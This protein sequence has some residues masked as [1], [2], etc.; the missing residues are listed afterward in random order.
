MNHKRR[1][2][3]FLMALMLALSGCSG[4]KPPQMADA[5]ATPSPTAEVTA[6]PEVTDTPKPT[7][8]P[9]PIPQ[10]ML[11]DIT[12]FPPTCQANGYSV[13]VSR[14]TGGINVRDEVPRLQHDYGE[15]D[16]DMATG[17]MSRACSMCGGEDKRRAD[18]LPRLLLFG[19]TEALASLGE[20]DMEVRFIHPGASDGF[21]GWAR[22]NW[23]GYSDTARMK[24]DVRVRFFDDE[25]LEQ[26]HALTLLNGMALSEYPLSANVI[27]STQQRHMICARVWRQISEKSAVG[28]SL[29]VTIYVNGDFRGLYALTLPPGALL[30]GMEPGQRQAAVTPAFDG[31]RTPMLDPNANWRVL[32]NGEGDEAWILDELHDLADFLRDS[33]DADLHEQL[34]AYLDTDSAIDYMLF[35]YAMG[36]SQSSATDVALLKYDYDPWIIA[37]FDMYDAFNLDADGASMASDAFLPEKRSDGVWDSG[38]G[39]VLWNRLLNVFEDDVARRWAELRQDVFTEENLDQQVS[40]LMDDMPATVFRADR[41]LYRRRALIS[42]P[43]R[44]MRDFVHERLNILDGI[45]GNSE[46]SVQ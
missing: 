29:P 43:A 31:R 44:Q 22:V 30:Y 13:Y 5:T 33:P 16:I 3:P 45:L 10:E 27:D 37:P 42:D 26:P 1:I 46:S 41:A 17:A 23:S 24:Q 20:A 4:G 6:A 28:D 32:F 9:T 12:V 25:A 39:S 18:G 2:I 19:D 40:A 34:R 38:T 8:T 14:E 7:P 15:W 21:A 11:F 35:M 36:L